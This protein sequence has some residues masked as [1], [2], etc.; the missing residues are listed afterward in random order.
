MYIAPDSAQFIILIYTLQLDVKQ[1][2]CIAN[3][4]AAASA[5]QRRMN[6]DPLEVMLMNMGYRMGRGS[7]RDNTASDS[8]ATYEDGGGG[9]MQCRP[10]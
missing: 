2:R 7:G 9:D 4:Y 1:D 3:Y 8:E 5:N 10:F 6:A